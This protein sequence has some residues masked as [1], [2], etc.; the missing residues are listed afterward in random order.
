[1]PR[2]LIQKISKYLP[3]DLSEEGVIDFIIKNK[4]KILQILTP[5]EKERLVASIL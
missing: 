4:D 1:M 5:Y 2:T 3:E